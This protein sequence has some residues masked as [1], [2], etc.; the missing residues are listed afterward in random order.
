MF[1]S[2]TGVR[3][4]R[5]EQ[6]F[7]DHVSRHE[8]AWA[9]HTENK[10][11]FKYSCLFPCCFSFLFFCS[12]S[13]SR[14]FILVEHAL[15]FSGAM[16]ELKLRKK[17]SKNGEEK[18]FTTRR[19]NNTRQEQARKHSNAHTNANKCP[20]TMWNIFEKTEITSQKNEGANVRRER[21][22]WQCR[23][24]KITVEKYKC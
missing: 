9:L 5:C 1:S 11:A 17:G 22:Y 4:F 8:C 21:R 20:H 14:E 6:R 12:S 16:V 7:V 10:I 23:Y 13:H 15:A 3:R 24:R 19:Q 2:F 18:K